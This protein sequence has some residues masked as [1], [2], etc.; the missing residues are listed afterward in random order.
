MTVTHGITEEQVGE[1]IVKMAAAL[2]GW[3][4]RD[5]RISLV[6]VR[7]TEAPTRLGRRRAQR[8]H[9]RIIGQRYVV[10]RMEALYVAQPDKAPLILDVLYGLSM[11]YTDEPE[12]GHTW[13]D[14]WAMVSLPAPL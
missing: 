1:V 14:V 2:R 7:E 3:L 4:D 5:K 10:E 6:A 11:P 12:Y 9:N 8:D 13:A